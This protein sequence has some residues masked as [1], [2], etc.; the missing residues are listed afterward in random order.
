MK[1]NYPVFLLS[2]KAS[3]CLLRLVGALLLALLPA[4][5]GTAPAT[6]QPRGDWG[7]VDALVTQMMQRYDI[8]GVAVGL[9]QNGQVVYSKGYGVRDVRTG[10]PVTE[11]TIFGIGSLSKSFTS[12][13]ILQQVD[14]GKLALDAPVITYLPDFKLA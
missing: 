7:Q 5:C 12:L 13:G 14:A 10:A 8:P 9:V 3:A 11:Q 2:Q 4:A 1:E 6:P